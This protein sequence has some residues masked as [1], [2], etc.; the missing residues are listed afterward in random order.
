MSWIATAAVTIVVGTGY[1]V[2]RGLSA[3]R[4]QKRAARA[5]AEARKVS[6]AQ[7]ENERQGRATRH[8]HPWSYGSASQKRSD[9]NTDTVSFTIL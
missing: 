7:Q 6:A 2:E 4:E 3:S 1:Q 9:R 8:C 5:E